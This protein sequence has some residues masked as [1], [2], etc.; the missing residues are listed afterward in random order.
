MCPS[1]YYAPARNN[2][3]VDQP[4]LK[5]WSIFPSGPSMMLMICVSDKGEN[6]VSDIFALLYLNKMLQSKMQKVK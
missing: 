3:T 2:N 1:F 4:C 6:S 5:V